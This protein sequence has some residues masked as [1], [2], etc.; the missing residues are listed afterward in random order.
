MMK[1]ILLSLLVTLISGSANAD[2]IFFEYWAGEGTAEHPYLISNVQDLKYLEECSHYHDFVGYCFKIVVPTLVFST[3]L[4]DDGCNFHPI[5]NFHGQLDGNGVVIQNMIIDMP[6]TEYLGVGLFI[7]NFGTVK[8]ITIDSNC[9]IVGN[10]RAGGIA[11]YNHGT[12]DNCVN[13]ASVTA[14]VAGGIA[15]FNDGHIYSG[16]ITN[17]EN[18]GTITS[19]DA[20][21]GYAGGVVGAGGTS[22]TCTNC[23]NSGIVNGKK[24][25]GGIIGYL[26]NESGALTNCTNNGDVTGTE[27]VGGVVGFIY[28][29]GGLVSG[30][31]NSGKVT[32]TG[33]NTG[34]IAG[35][36][37]K[38]IIACSNSGEVTG[39]YAVG[40]ISGW[41]KVGI[42][43]ESVN[44]GKILGNNKYVGGITGLTSLG[45]AITDC[46]NR[47]AVEGRESV[48]GGITGESEKDSEIRDCYNY[49][50]IT[51][52]AYAGG[53]SGLNS[54]G[55]TI[56]DCNNY[57]EVVCIVGDDSGGFAGG[58]VA[59]NNFIS[60]SSTSNTSLIKNCINEGNV[61]G[62][63]SIGGIAGTNQGE[64]GNPNAKIE[65][66]TNKGIVSGNSNVGGIAGGQYK[67]TISGCCNQGDVIGNM[68][69]GAIIGAMGTEST[70]SENYYLSSVIVKVGSTSYTGDTPRGE[71]KDD[72][73]APVDITTHNGAVVRLV[74]TQ[75]VEVITTDGETV[76]TDITTNMTDEA[77]KEVEVISAGIPAS[78]A[79]SSDVAIPGSVTIG[80]TDY[81]VTSIA[82]NSF[83][84]KTEI[85]NIYL[86]ET[87]TKLTLGANALKIDDTNVATIHTSLAL[88]DDYTTDAVLDQN[89]VAGKV[90]TTVT[91]A[92]QYWTF[93]C[94]VDVEVPDGVSV[95]ICKINGSEV[96]ITE[97]TADQLTVNGKKIIKAN[98]GVLL[99]S[100]A[101]NPCKMIAV[102]N[103][104]IT[105]VDATKDAKSYGADNALEPVIATNHYDPASYY[106]LYQGKFVAIASDDVTKTPACKALLKK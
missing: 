90:Q 84:G 64:D 66:C 1:K 34:G 33:E 19:T 73:V 72:G 52:L 13:K 31:T 28:S 47:G 27:Y 95:Y 82:P 8:N 4:G 25:T 106:M 2:P 53:I 105:I 77:N 54:S 61:S 7:Q 9:R 81:Q 83:A 11:G 10:Q 76:K 38:K 75:T 67:Q 101:G 96:E 26:Q 58:I 35:Y 51:A 59:K 86:P 70:M 17:C 63:N 80:S 42:I 65:D 91:P 97:L 94:G 41:V 36:C 29:T 68:W 85:E 23:S 62:L 98:N 78:E 24:Y 44:T 37:E 50:K 88:L 30:C 20:T 79:G 39:T 3:A 55:S 92:N 15:G 60:G 40:G 48:V 45:S 74:P 57:G 87:D 43:E 6:T 32:G 69:T 104:D 5:A 71:G 22:G 21:E 102:K 14:C 103:A 89:L 46:I 93:A 99:L 18:N 12:I 49:A 16:K 56:E 100:T